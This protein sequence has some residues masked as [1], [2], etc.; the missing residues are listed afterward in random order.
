MGKVNNIHNIPEIV[1][2]SRWV[3]RVSGL[4]GYRLD[5]DI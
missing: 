4:L 2:G 3:I 1:K 5:S